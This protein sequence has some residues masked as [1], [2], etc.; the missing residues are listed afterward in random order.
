MARKL[1]AKQ[2][3]KANDKRIESLYHQ[4]CYGIQIDIMD[5]A[6]VF[7]AGKQAIAAGVDDQ[8][9]GD[10]IAAFVQTIRKN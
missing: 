10:A 3:E 6:K 9:L 4:R 1:T 8:D 5:I 2:Q 7:A